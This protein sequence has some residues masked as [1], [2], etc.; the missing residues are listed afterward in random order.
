MGVA[1]FIRFHCAARGAGVVSRAS[2][3]CVCSPLHP[4]LLA[5]YV[6]W[7]ANQMAAVSTKRAGREGPGFE[8]GQTLALIGRDGAVHN[9]SAVDAFPGVEDEE[10]VGKPLQHHQALALWTIHNQ[11]PKTIDLLISSYS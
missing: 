5:M 10:E 9:G 1:V 4:D 8:P 7:K 6:V 11:P 2:P 3:G